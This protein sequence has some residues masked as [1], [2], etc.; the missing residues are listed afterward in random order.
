[1]GRGGAFRGAARLATASGAAARRF[2]FDDADPDRFQRVVIH[3]RGTYL[4]IAFRPDD[5]ALEEAALIDDIELLA[6]IGRRPHR[7]PGQRQPAAARAGVVAVADPGGSAALL[8]EDPELDIAGGHALARPDA[9]RLDLAPA[10]RV[11]GP[12]GLDI[13]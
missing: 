2:L 10:A 8:R 12:A 7:E 13:A 1:A 11:A 9:D 5:A 6:L 4:A 3:R